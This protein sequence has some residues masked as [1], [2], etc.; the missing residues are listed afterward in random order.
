MSSPW[1]RAGGPDLPTPF[2]ADQIQGAMPVGLKLLF[3][4]TQ[5]EGTQTQVWQVV[6]SDDAGLQITV[7]TD[8]GPAEAGPVMPWTELRDHARFGATT[9]WT[10][11]VI[12]SPLGPVSTRRY[13]EVRGDEVHTFW[14]AP[15]WPGPPVRMTV[16]DGDGVQIMEQVL[17]ER[18]V[19]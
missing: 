8:G 18:I 9:T 14:F 10:D 16:V 12:R 6:A 15:A 17:A 13:T 3:R 5:G 2:T 4:L 7:A 11:E 19:P 1:S